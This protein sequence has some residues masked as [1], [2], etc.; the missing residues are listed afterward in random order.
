MEALVIQ[1]ALNEFEKYH[2]Q[3]LDWYFRSLSFRWKSDEW[4]ICRLKYRIYRKKAF[5]TIKKLWMN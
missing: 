5:K 1:M 3:S 2:N 4:L